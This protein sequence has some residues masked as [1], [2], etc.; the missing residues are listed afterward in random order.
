MCSAH[1]VVSPPDIRHIESSNLTFIRSLF[2][3][4]Y[5]I[6]ICFRFF[7]EFGNHM[8]VRL[9]QAS[10][11]LQHRTVV[12]NCWL[13]LYHMGKLVVFSIWPYF[14][15][16]AYLKIKP[17]KNSLNASLQKFSPQDF[18]MNYHGCC[19]QDCNIL[20]FF[21][22]HRAVEAMLVKRIMEWQIR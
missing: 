16:T 5:Y 4:S 20:L 15:V 19:V 8:A 6:I 7:T 11:T 2:V 1:D 13:N 12:R 3:R 14:C 10:Q 21:R 9:S 17:K 18:L 22:A